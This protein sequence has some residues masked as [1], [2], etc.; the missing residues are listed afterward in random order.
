[1][2]RGD[3]ITVNGKIHTVVQKDSKCKKYPRYFVIEGQYG[4]TDI[5]NMCDGFFR[6]GFPVRVDGTIGV[7]DFR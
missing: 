7:A 2:K 3:Q 5:D 6:P 4:K 1:M